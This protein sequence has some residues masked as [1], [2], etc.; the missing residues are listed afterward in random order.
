MN[1]LSKVADKLR[2]RRNTN[3]TL[4]LLHNLSAKELDDI[5]LTRGDIDRVARGVLDVHR[6]ARDE[7]KTKEDK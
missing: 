5:G 6:I 7:V 1:L 4:K 2:Q 3:N